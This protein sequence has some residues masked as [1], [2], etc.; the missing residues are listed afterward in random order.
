MKNKIKSAIVFLFVSSCLLSFHANAQV[1]AHFSQYYAYPLWLN[2][3]LTGVMDGD[4]RLTVNYKRQWA[5]ITSPFTTEAV[6][7]DTYPY[8]HM[9]I[10]GTILNQSAGDGGYNYLNAVASAAYRA[11]LDARGMNIL[12]IGLQAGIINRRFNPNKLQFGSQYSP[13]LGFN[14]AAPSGENF[15]K[16]SATAFDANFGMVYF[17]GDPNTRLNPFGG[18]SVYH[19]TRPQDPFLTGG[20]SRLPMRLDVHG[21]VR[22]KLDEKLDLTPQAIYIR[23]GNAHET[24]AGVYA[25]YLLQ[26]FSDLLF[27][28]TYRVQ[29]ALIPFV[30]FHIN[31]FTFGLSYD[32]NVSQLRTA[33]EGRGGLEL[34]LSYIRHKKIQDP[35][36]IC[37]RL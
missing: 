18:V 11:I 29:D 33:S 1:D 6:S 7:F 8:K 36:F 27:G 19:L 30:G 12:S 20:N 2:P 32:I 14:P 37:P 13:I 4:Y 16:T 9:G 24:A 31:D 22:I 34:S 26:N 35:R 17:N 23:Q 3:G 25:Q 10:G 28:A 15:G 5:A 21:G